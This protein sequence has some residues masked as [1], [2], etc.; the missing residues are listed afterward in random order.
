M[1]QWRDQCDEQ[2]RHF[3]LAKSGKSLSP[4][5]PDLKPRTASGILVG[6][7]ENHQDDIKIFR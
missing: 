4:S 1:E 7:V 2:V 5:E 3:Y 6:K